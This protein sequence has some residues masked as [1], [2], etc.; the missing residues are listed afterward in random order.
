[1]LLMSV[2]SV[3]C[4]N[5]AIEMLVISGQSLTL[6]VRRPDTGFNLA[7]EMLVISGKPP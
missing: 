1:M 4:F 5:L 7:I 6:S 3:L 2:R